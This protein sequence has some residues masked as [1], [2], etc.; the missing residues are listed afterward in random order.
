MTWGQFFIYQGF[1]A[2]LGWMHTSSGV[3]IVE[4]GDKVSARAISTGGESGDPKSP[5]FNDQAARD[6]DG[7]LREVYFYPAQLVDH[8]ER[9]YHPH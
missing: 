1:N 8:T 5:P 7:S 6:A 9:E 4:F 2:R 3:A